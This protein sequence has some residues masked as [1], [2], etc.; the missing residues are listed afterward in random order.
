VEVS[1][2]NVK[3]EFFQL[4][5]SLHVIHFDFT[6]VILVGKYDPDPR[7]M[8]VFVVDIQGLSALVLHAVDM[9]LTKVH[10]TEYH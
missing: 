9:V 4:C 10:H 7:F 5:Q 6:D 2:G 8:Q 3:P 1:I